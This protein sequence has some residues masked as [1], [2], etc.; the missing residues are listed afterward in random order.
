M[1]SYGQQD[2]LALLSRQLSVS[3]GTDTL[4]VSENQTISLSIN[5]ISEIITINKHRVMDR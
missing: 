4:K 2:S 3:H 5:K 1:L